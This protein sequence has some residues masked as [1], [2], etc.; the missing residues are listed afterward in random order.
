MIQ[1]QELTVSYGGDQLAL[2]K[3]SVRIENWKNSWHPWAQWSWQIDLY[4]GPS[5]LG[6]L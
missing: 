3:V 2:D 1:T 4:E 6:R 5:W